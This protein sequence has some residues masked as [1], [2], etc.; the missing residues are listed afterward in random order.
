MF[1]MFK[2]KV[3]LLDTTSK[4]ELDRKEKLLKDAGIKTNSWST[5][6]FPVIGGPHMKPAD[7]QSLGDRNKDDE[8]SLYHLEVAAEDQYKAMK[9]L[10]EDGGVDVT[11]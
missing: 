10:L 11:K 4:K 6:A 2:K 3:T 5:E 9:I 7:W 1:W 8:R